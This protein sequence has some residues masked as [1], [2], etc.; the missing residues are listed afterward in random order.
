MLC[1]SALESRFD[2][3]GAKKWRSAWPKRPHIM[4]MQRTRLG[5]KACAQPPELHPPWPRLRVRIADTAPLGTA[6]LGALL[7]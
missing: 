4:C 2:D 5:Q 6:L 7:I 1:L 3:M